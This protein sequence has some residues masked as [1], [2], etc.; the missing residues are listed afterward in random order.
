MA[1]VRSRGN[2]ETE[3]KM[4]KLLRSAGLTGWRRHQ[5]VKGNPDFVF[6]RERIALFVDGCFWHGCRQHC[7]M[8][9]ANRSYWQ[10][11]ILRNT[12]RDRKTT[13]TLKAAGWKVIRV[14]SHALRN[15]RVVTTRIISE[16][17]LPRRRYKHIRDI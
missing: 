14:W 6:R 13:R 2:K 11:K 15:P 16:L 7:R 5:R 4:A 12:V 17:N 9:A 8:P 10:S 3:V 1:A